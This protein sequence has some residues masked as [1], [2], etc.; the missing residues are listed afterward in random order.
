MPIHR[1][2]I[3]ESAGGGGIGSDSFSGGDTGAAAAVC[4]YILLNLLSSV[5]SP[6][7]E[8]GKAKPLRM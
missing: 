3:T 5:Q 2:L 4:Y 8:K 1:V 6:M 7:S